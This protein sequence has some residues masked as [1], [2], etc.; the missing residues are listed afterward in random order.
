MQTNNR[1][2]DDLAKVAN[3]AVSTLVGIK[4]EI[5]AIVNQRVERFL[6]DRD[7]VL[8]DEFEA[9]KAVAAAA[10]A[11]EEKLERRVAALEAALAAK[12]KPAA[13][14]RA[15]RKV[16]DKAAGRRKASARRPAKGA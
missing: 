7:L 2:L 6:G 14:K 11:G 15:A 9:V 5:E 8:R 4:D 10:R 16:G 1:F 13:P 3:S 12:G